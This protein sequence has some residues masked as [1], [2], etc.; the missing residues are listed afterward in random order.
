MVG[1]SLCV[2]FAVVFA[3]AAFAVG[4]ASAFAGGSFSATG[5]AFFA[6]AAGCCGFGIAAIFVAIAGRSRRNAE[7]SEG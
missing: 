2:V 5:F 1:L 3:F 4:A 6:G 7:R